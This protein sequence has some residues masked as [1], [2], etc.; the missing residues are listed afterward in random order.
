MPDTNR[1]YWGVGKVHVR[2]AG[3]T[4]AWR[5]VGNCSL[6]TLQHELDIKRQP[7]Y[8]RLGGGT[9]FRA[10]RIQQVNAQMTWLSF[11]PE[12]MA[13]A[14]AGSQTAVTAG[15]ATAEVVKGHKG[16]LVRLAFPPLAITTV[17][18][19]AATTT[20]V[21]GTDYEKSP[22]GLSIPDASTIVN[23][24][25]LKVTYTYAAHTRIEGAMAPSSLLECVFE[26]LNEADSGK[27]VIVDLWKASFPAAEQ[28]ALIGDDPGD[29]TFAA[30]L[31]KDASKGNTVSAFYRV[32]ML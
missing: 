24:A 20:Y 12:N 31:L 27:Q 17:T 4:G 7:D 21:A 28:I 30:E 19:S 3:T 29:L 6:L 25:D 8:T 16:A 22:G 18:D 5:H 14:T 23:A 32:Q 26:G 13:L 1:S 9:A 10:E 11:S 2:A 15:T